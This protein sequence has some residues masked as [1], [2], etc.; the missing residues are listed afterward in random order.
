MALSPHD[1]DELREHVAL[2]AIGA[3][4]ASERQVAEAHMSTCAECA[5]ELR[6]LLPV[7]GVLAQAI[8]QVDP[9]PELRDRVLRSIAGDRAARRVARAPGLR[10][11]TSR[12]RLMP[13]LAAA[14]MLVAALAGGYALQL[15]RAAVE[16]E[17]RA[18]LLE[19]PD[20]VRVD[21]AG[22][23]VAPQA[24]GRAYVTRSRGVM[25][26]ASNLPALPAG[27]VY[28]L[29]V[30]A[31]QAPPISRGWLLRPDSSGR[32]TIVFDSRGDLPRPTA[33]AVTIEP[34]GGV[35]APTG[36]KYLVGLASSS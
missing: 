22:Q 13:W 6:S 5:E 12:H 20:L 14:A 30:L 36:D 27:R 11:N 31:G 3:L 33:V 18:A 32:A 21:L 4:T 1:H 17:S 19:S 16:A 34:D 7:T 10:A 35:P 15:R 29:W 8:P 25:I 26:S 23:P 24:S 28:Q 9:S 2:Y